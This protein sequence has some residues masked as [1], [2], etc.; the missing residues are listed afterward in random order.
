VGRPRWRQ[1]ELEHIRRISPYGIFG[2]SEGDEYERAYLG[3]L[4][5][6]DV[7][8]LAQ[9][10]DDLSAKHGGE[11]LVLLCFER[12]RKPAGA[13][14]SALRSAPSHGTNLPQ[15]A[16]ALRSKKEPRPHPSRSA[17][18]WSSSSAGSCRRVGQDCRKASRSA[19]IVSAWVV[20]M[21]CGNPL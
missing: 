20:G 8:A 9:R 10:F 21:P 1:G 18:A 14:A 2:V 15:G 11:A 5:R 3:R 7:T 13:R 16:A 12:K 6:L 4:D 17:E 19:L